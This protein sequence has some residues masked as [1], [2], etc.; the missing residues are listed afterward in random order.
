MLTVQVP[1][2][3]DG[4]SDF[5]RLFNLW[6]QLNGDGLHV[7]C[8]F[9]RCGFLRQNAVAFLGGLIRV[10]QYRGGTVSIDWDSMQSQ[11]IGN[12]DKNGFR[13][14]FSDFHGPRLGNTIPF[15]EDSL[16]KVDKEGVIDYLQTKWLGRGWLHV[17][18]A[19]RDA[20]VGRMWEI[21]SNAFEHS[22]S[23]VG[24]FSCGQ[25]FPRL[26]ALNLTVVDFGVGIPS[27]VRLFGQNPSLRAGK[28][29]EWAFRPG[30][31]TKP[32]GLGRGVGLDLLKSFVRLNKGKV[33]VFSHEGY[34]LIGETGESFQVRENSFEG[35]LV[36]IKLVCDE[37]YY[38][39][40]SEVPDQPLF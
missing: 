37:S 32:N 29:M 14:T 21:Y 30:T 16:T 19:L 3:N 10:V 12:L 5:D 24:L 2:I 33:E 23:P 20:I 17:S 40:S 27:N 11:V 31:T 4:L 26:H 25:F 22:D 18:T 6:G 38:C 1:T 9:S 15:R 34:A 36:N 35:T 8:D 28:A 7:S 13:E 39:F